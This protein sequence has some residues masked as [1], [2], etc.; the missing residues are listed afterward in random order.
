MLA[1]HMCACEAPAGRQPAV[2]HQACHAAAPGHSH[3]SLSPPVV[4]AL[5][6]CRCV[7]WFVLLSYNIALVVIFAVGAQQ[8]PQVVFLDVS[9]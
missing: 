6:L 3:P 8:Q 1:V 2:L 9:T 7:F 5:H 4:R